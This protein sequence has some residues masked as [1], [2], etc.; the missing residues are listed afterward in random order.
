[1]F[2]R[3]PFSRLSTCCGRTLRRGHGGLEF[4]HVGGSRIGDGEVQACPAASRRARDTLRGAK[5]SCPFSPAITTVSSRSSPGRTVRAAIRSTTCCWLR[6]ST[7]ATSSV[8]PFNFSA[9]KPLCNANAIGEPMPAGRDHRDADIAA[10]NIVDAHRAAV[11]IELAAHRI[12]L[13]RPRC[14]RWNRW[15]RTAPS[16]SAAAS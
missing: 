15:R 12:R 10:I 5:L 7:G 9:S 3:S 13:R 1:M 11:E 2:E 6:R 8:T 16:A 4:D 14:A